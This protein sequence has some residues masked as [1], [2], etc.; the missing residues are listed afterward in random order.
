MKLTFI[1][2]GKIK[3]H[4]YEEGIKMYIKRISK[5]SQVEFINLDESRL[6]TSTSKIEIDRGLD[7]EAEKMDDQLHSATGRGLPWK[8]EH[9]AMV[10]Y[11]RSKLNG[12]LLDSHDAGLEIVYVPYIDKIVLITG[13]V[14]CQQTAVS[15]I[16]ELISKEA[17]V[18]QVAQTL[19]IRTQDD[20][21]ID[22][23]SLVYA[24]QYAGTD[25]LCAIPSWKVDYVLKNADENTKIR[26]S[27][28]LWIDAVSGFVAD[29]W[30]QD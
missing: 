30:K 14:P 22:A 26:D 6:S 3:E 24:M 28:S 4:F 10:V 15:K 16:S 8:K 20:I 13:H 11:Y 9:E 19:G 23:V 21:Q 1:L 27:G 5:Y 2:V 12:M 18:S 29:Y 25:Q 7:E 17:A